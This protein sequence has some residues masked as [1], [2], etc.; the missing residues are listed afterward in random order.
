MIS[1]LSHALL[2]LGLDT[3]WKIVEV[4]CSC[5]LPVL[6]MLAATGR[7][8]FAALVATALGPAAFH[9]RRIRFHISHITAPAVRAAHG[10]RACPR[11]G[12]F[13]VGLGT[14]LPEDL[15]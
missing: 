9:T 14:V 4:V 2:A 5:R 15:R 3:A 10:D 1:R 8:A 13:D 11:T 6:G 7:D 12:G